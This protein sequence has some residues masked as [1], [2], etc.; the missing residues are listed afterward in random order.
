M[1]F[2]LE[3]IYFIVKQIYANVFTF[4]WYLHSFLHHGSNQVHY[5][6]FQ[7]FPDRIGGRKN[8]ITLLPYGRILGTMIRPHAY[9]MPT[10]V[11]NLTICQWRL[12]RNTVVIHRLTHRAS[13]DKI[14]WRKPMV[15]ILEVTDI[16]MLKMVWDLVRARKWWIPDENKI[17]KIK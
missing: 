3:F 8:K 14:F 13:P 9:H 5:W 11:I 10:T 6:G 17:I 15:L 12:R 1:I 16:Q 7:G 2:S 4:F